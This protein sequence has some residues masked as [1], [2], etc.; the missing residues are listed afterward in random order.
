MRYQRLLALWVGLVL[1]CLQLVGPVAH[2]RWHAAHSE[3]CATQGLHMG[4]VAP[5]CDFCLVAAQPSVCTWTA[6]VVVFLPVLL[7]SAPVSPTQTPSLP[8]VPQRRG[9]PR[10]PP[11]SA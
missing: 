8:H 6:P 5:E 2:A 4:A 1:L 9:P 7:T 10:A 11:V 3:S